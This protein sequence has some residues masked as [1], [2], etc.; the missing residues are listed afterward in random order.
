VLF[1]SA[2]EQDSSHATNVV[3]VGETSADLMLC[4]QCIT[5]FQVFVEISTIIFLIFPIFV[6]SPLFIY[7]NAFKLCFYAVSQGVGI[8]SLQN[9]ILLAFLL[10]YR[11]CGIAYVIE[12]RETGGEG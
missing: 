12:R 8:I 11:V 5:V 7:P 1:K 6:C 2:I 3:F 10:Y 9:G 4:Y